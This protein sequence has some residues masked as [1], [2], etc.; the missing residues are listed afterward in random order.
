[1]YFSKLSTFLISNFSTFNSNNHLTQAFSCFFYPPPSPVLFYKPRPFYI[2]S[3]WSLS[4]L[5]GSTLALYM[6][7]TTHLI[8]RIVILLYKKGV[9]NN[10]TNFLPD[11]F[12]NRTYINYS[13]K[14]LGCNKNQDEDRPLQQAGFRRIYSTIDSLQTLIKRKRIGQELFS[15]LLTMKRHLIWQTKKQ[16][17]KSINENCIK[18]IE[19]IY[20][21]TVLQ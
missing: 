11:T 5:L 20:R 16:K 7:I 17:I 4:S 15:L 14:Y 12:F 1:M 3:L 18:A 8:T 19:N 6:S 9:D 10:L 2:Q 13:Q 21:L